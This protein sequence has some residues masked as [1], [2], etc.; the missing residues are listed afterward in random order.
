MA[1]T[2]A[3]DAPVH[4]THVFATVRTGLAYFCTGFAVEGVVIA[5]AAHEV[6]ACCAG[7]DAVEHQFDVDL[8]DVITAFG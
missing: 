6:D 5:V 2:T 1:L 4:A 7:R 8:L 3:L